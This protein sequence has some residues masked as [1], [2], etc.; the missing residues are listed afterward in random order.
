MEVGARGE[1]CDYGWKGT[2]EDAVHA[3][4]D[5]DEVG[6][7]GFERCAGEYVVGR[8]AVPGKTCGGVRGEICECAYGEVRA[9]REHGNG[10]DSGG[11]EGDRDQAGRRSDCAGVHMGRNGWAGATGERG[12]GVRGC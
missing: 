3:M 11:A 10:G 12:S 9:V 6:G 8:A 5:C 7:R 1:T 4:A 2:E